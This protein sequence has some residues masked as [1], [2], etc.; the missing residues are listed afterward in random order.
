MN[1]ATSRHV[2]RIIGRLSRGERLIA[3]LEKICRKEKIR[4]GSIQAVGLL[5]SAQL[6]SYQSPTGYETSLEANETCELLSLRGNI[7]TLAD[8]IILNCHAQ[9][10][11]SHLG[12]NRVFGGQLA[13]ASALAVEFVIEAYDD[14]IMERRLE[15]R[16][17]LPLLN[18]IETTTGE[19]TV[20]R[21]A[22]S[23]AAPAPSFTPAPAPV[24]A[25][26]PAPTPAPVPEPV[27]APEP[28]PEDDFE[29][30]LEDNFEPEPEAVASPE[31]EVARA[32]AFSSDGQAVTQAPE[33]T[34]M[35]LA[36][37]PSEE[38]PA[39]EKPSASWADAMLVSEQTETR[40]RMG[41]EKKTK[42]G[43]DAAA[44]ARK[45]VSQWKDQ[46]EI[47][48]GDFMRHPHFGECK[49]LFVEEDDYVK[50]R[51]RGGKVVDIKLAVCELSLDGEKNGQNVFNCK[52]VRR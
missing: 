28:E 23:Q 24:A 18:R 30:E 6:Q 21:G 46:A 29:P 20:E 51:L 38:K 40:Q 2:R 8:A 10:G 16:L 31:P 12:Q 36:T 14:I 52:I 17:G 4:A 33:P 48:A 49:V 7:S 41:V 27:A 25:P 42:P 43:E 34:V 32:T 39:E 3:S 5:S 13:D 11:V 19:A 1:Y 15:S 35:R 26:A 37:R 9:I 47:Q 50:V 45:V 44:R 22:P